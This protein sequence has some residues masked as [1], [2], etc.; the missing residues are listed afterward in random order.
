MRLSS[1]PLIDAPAI[2]ARVAELARAIAQDYVGR[3]PI[4]LCVLK[5]ALHFTSDLARNMTSP[6]GIEFIRAS[7]YAGTE[8]TGSVKIAADSLGHL[9]GR[10]VILVE[11]ILDTGRTCATLLEHVRSLEPASLRLC[12]LL[13]KPSRRVLPVMADYVGFS[14]DDHF[15]VGYGLD[16]DEQYRELPAIHVLEA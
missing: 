15:V 6:V 14:I 12:T 11:D 13:D 3:V 9:S 16:H 5:G 1:E 8:S 10:D 7:S 2:D 4:L